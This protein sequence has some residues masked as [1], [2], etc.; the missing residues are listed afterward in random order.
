MRDEVAVGKA[1]QRIGDRLDGQRDGLGLL[2][3][4]RVALAALLFAQGLVF[5][6]RT[7]E[8]R[9]LDDVFAEDG[10]GSPVLGPCA[11]SGL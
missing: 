5:F 9:A 6:R 2:R 8:A 7:G 3:L 11:Q 1:A 10:D 4:D